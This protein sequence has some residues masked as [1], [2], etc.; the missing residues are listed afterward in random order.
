[1]TNGV[2]VVTGASGLIGRAL[3][4][5]LRAARR[6]LRLVSRTP[7]QL[8]PGADVETVG[9]DGL[10]L[11]PKALDGAS[12]VVHLAGEPIFAGVPTRTRRERMWA[13]RIRSTKRLVEQIAAQPSSERPGALV[14]ASAVGFYGDR[15]EEELPEAAPPGAG[16]LADLCAA[17]EEEAARAAEL[18]LRVVQLRF[19][20]VLSMRGGA[21][22]L[23]ARAFRL[24]LGGRIGSGRQWFPWIHRDDAVALARRALDDASVVGPLNAVAPGAVRNADFTRA[25]ASAVHRPALLPAPAFAVRLALGELAVELLGS[26]H[27]L[28]ARAEAL[29]H[30]FVH[31]TLA[32]ALAAELQ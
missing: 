21:L 12:A 20:V 23:L 29:G 30:R 11:E 28:P 14:C 4:A 16:F 6:R 26:R 10:V 31:P 2:T 19:G 22:P 7:D 24:G 5:E 9:W 3:V 1:V 8:A 17:W 18:G 13:S 32:T 15:G 25:V 27:V